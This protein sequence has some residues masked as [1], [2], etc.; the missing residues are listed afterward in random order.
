M[1]DSTPRSGRSEAKPARVVAATVVDRRRLSPSFA[2]LTLSGRDLDRFAYVGYDQWFRLFIPRE[3]EG[4]MPLPTDDRADGWYAEHQAAPEE[5]RNWMRYATVADFRTA[6]RLGG[7]SNGGQELDVDV[8]VHGEAGDPGSGPLSTWAQTAAVGDRVALLDQGTIFRPEK[9]DT[10]V[11]LIGDETAV[12]AIAGI[13]R[14]L[15]PDVHGHAFLEVPYAEDV[16]ELTGFS[17]V[18]VTWLPRHGVA[19]V[20]G[21][22][23]LDAVRAHLPAGG[24]F[25][26][27]PPHGVRDSEEQSVPYVYGAGEMKLTKALNELFRRERGWPNEA[28]TVV[29]YWHYPG[30]G[31][32]R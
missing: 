8:V 7:A 1:A 32:L 11:L 14:R 4:R 19:D 2:R 28:L 30:G 22:R 15:A 31:E 5:R 16:Q 27:Q 12:P 10:E 17:R 24:T 25:A 9:V 13:L 23:L 20:P 6:D 26:E 21:Q 3:G 18:K 29:G